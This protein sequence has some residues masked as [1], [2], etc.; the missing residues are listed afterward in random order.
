M[1]WQNTKNEGYWL[2]R[3]HV[4]EWLSCDGVAYRSKQICLE[5]PGRLKP[6]AALAVQYVIMGSQDL[7]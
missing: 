3:E 6:D 5:L 1:V 7:K 2:L 4:L